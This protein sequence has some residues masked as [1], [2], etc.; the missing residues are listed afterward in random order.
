MYFFLLP[1][2]GDPYRAALGM[3]AFGTVRMVCVKYME[4][5]GNPG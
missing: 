2:V 4:A 5:K 3:V 1:P